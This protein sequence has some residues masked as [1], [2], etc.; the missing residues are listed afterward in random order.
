[1]H[2]FQIKRIKEQKYWIKLNH[3]LKG[4][5]KVINVLAARKG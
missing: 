2:G 1:M 5:V 4:L 3:D